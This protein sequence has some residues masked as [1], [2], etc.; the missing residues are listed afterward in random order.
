M[1]LAK[2]MTGVMTVLQ[3]FYIHEFIIVN[4]EKDGYGKEEYNIYGRQY[5][6]NGISLI[7]KYMG[8]EGSIKG[9]S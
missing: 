5:K 8:S 4:E 9:E 2:S 3:S 7:K 1:N 6:I